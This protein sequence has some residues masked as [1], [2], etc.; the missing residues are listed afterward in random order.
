MSKNISTTE[1]AY[2]ALLRRKAE[3]L[4]QKEEKAKVKK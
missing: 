2:Q 3:L 4:K 1:T